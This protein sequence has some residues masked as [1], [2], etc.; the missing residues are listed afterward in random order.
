MCTCSFCMFSDPGALYLEMMHR[1]WIIQQLKKL[2]D[3]P[4]YAEVL[5]LDT[6]PPVPKAGSSREGPPAKRTRS[7][8]AEPVRVSGS[9]KREGKQ[10]V[11]T[12][13]LRGIGQ[14][15]AGAYNLHDMKQ[16][17]ELSDYLSKNGGW[18]L[19]TTPKDGQCVFSSFL[20][21]M[22]CPEEYRASHLRFQFGHFVV[23]NPEFAFNRL[24]LAIQAEYGHPR[25]SREEYLR[26]ITSEEEPLT[27]DEI[28]DYQKPGPFSFSSY[29]QYMMADSSWGDEGT[30]TLIGMMWQVTITIIL[31]STRE[32]QV[33]RPH[34]F[35]QLKLRHNRNLEEVDFVLVYAGE[36]HYLGACEYNSIFRFSNIL[37]RL[38]P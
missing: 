27:E 11:P 8:T 7:A 6:T 33:G 12:E 16:V 18:E 20:K 13:R 3:T 4:E 38:Q 1:D 26:R 35:R 23:Q 34:T 30:I 31:V 5:L 9:P 15:Q 25:I 17:V 21:G 32:A 37:V 14:A 36:S 2:E 10:P 28:S 24:K 29:L 22:D 19:F